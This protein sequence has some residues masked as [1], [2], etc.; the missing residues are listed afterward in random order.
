MSQH[1]LESAKNIFFIALGIDMAVTVLVAISSY[2]TLGILNDIRQGGSEMD[3]STLSTI[4]FWESFAKVTIL[5]MIGVGLALVRWL[6]ACYEY[7]KETLMATGF[8]QEGWKTWGW[9]VPFMNLFKPY[10][11]LTEIYKVGATDYIGG[12][13]WKKSSGSGMLL[14][15]WI[16]WVIAHLIMGVIANQLL[17]SAARDDLT[18][19]NII[20]MYSFSVT[21]C[22]ISLIVAGLWFVV[23]GSLTRRLLSRSTAGAI[24]VK[25]TYATTPKYFSI[26]SESSQAKPAV[27]ILPAETEAVA[28]NL[29]LSVNSTQGRTDVVQ[30]RLSEEDLWAEALAEFESASRRPGLWAKAF[31]EAGGNESI[32]KSIYLRERAHQLIEAEAPKPPQVTAAQ[33]EL[34]RCVEALSALG[35]KATSKASGWE[36]KEPLGGRQ[37]ISTLSD[38]TQYA[39]ERLLAKK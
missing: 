10:K 20:S 26:V 22:V 5:T 12:D 27:P 4:E 28:G 9:I 2:W 33:A 14:V 21:I 8:V 29:R 30:K 3:Q 38:L 16:F 11:V 37:K 1:K 31:A 6:G 35:Y 13:E 7:A 39:N 24:S 36:I 23:V 34:N 17:N 18:L 19:N 25:P 15:W 32:A